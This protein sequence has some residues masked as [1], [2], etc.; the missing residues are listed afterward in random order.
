[1]PAVSRSLDSDSCSER[2]IVAWI[3][4]RPESSITWTSGLKVRRNWT[5][6]LRRKLQARDRAEARHDSFCGNI[7]G[8]VFNGVEVWVRCSRYLS[9]TETENAKTGAN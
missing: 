6:D 7:R 8:L 1:M 4:P 9:I 2:P 3:T 5:T